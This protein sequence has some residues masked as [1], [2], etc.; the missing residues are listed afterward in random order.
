MGIPITAASTGVPGLKWHHSNKT[1]KIQSNQEPMPFIPM[2]AK[3]QASPDEKST[4]M[5]LVTQGKVRLFTKE[6]LPLF[7][8]MSNVRGS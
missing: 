1:Q 3:A 8:R 7:Q 5:Q 6:A 2:F 4:E